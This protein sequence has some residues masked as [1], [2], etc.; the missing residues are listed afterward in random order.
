MTLVNP[1]PRELAGE[2]TAEDPQLSGLRK[3]ALLFAQLSKEEAATLL[4]ELR[5]PGGRTADR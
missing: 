2:P 4:P 3:A 1:G 5:P